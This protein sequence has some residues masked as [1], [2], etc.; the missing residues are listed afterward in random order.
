MSF[1]NNHRLLLGTIF[2][3]F[4]GLALIIAIGPA[5]W[6]Q[7][8]VQT[9]PSTHTL[10]EL[11]QQ[12]LEVYIAEGCVACHTQQ[13]RPLQMD[14]V[15]GRPSLPEDYA[16]LGPIDVWRPYTPAVLGSA[17]VG[18]DLSNI[19]ARQ[20]SATWQYLHLYN[21]RTVVPASIMPAYPWLFEAAPDDATALE[22]PEPFNP[23]NQVVPTEE[24]KALVAYLLSLRQSTAAASDTAA[25]DKKPAAPAAEA[26]SSGT[27]T[28]TASGPDGAALYSNN[29]ASCHQANGQGLPGIFP[30]LAGDPVVLA[31]DATEHIAIVLHGAHGRTIN[32]RT[33]ASPMPPFGDRFNDAEIA[34]M[35]NH[36]RSSWGNN[37]PTVSAEDVATVR[38]APP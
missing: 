32:G 30:P 11:E 13:V 27:T 37:A 17:R 14:A 3:G 28:R 1:H 9:G 20:P 22:I 26:A 2:L 19:G 36:E 33:Y 4:I 6:V 31:E 10:G 16:G 23:G 5:Y 29:C 38:A 8:K 15:W 18:P 35:V 7:Y 12:G 25:P 24:G 21:P 34:A